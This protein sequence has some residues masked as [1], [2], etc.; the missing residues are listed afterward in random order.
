[1]VVFDSIL[2]VF[3]K[4]KSVKTYILLSIKNKE[5]NK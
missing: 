1:M 5:I 4:H 2:V 3:E